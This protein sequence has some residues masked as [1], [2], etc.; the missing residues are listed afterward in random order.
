MKVAVI[1]ARGGSKRILGKNIKHFCGQPIISWSI[2]NAQKSSLFD[3]IIVST[4]SSEI[5]DVAMKYNAEVPFIRPANLADDYASTLA[6]MQHAAETLIGSGAAISH[7]CCIYATAPLLSIEALAEGMKRL[8]DEGVKF[9]FSAGRYNYPVQRAF[10][11][12]E[13]VGINFLFPENTEVRSQDL[14]EVYHDAGQFYWGKTNSWLTADQLLCKRALPIVIPT[15]RVQD[16][17]DMEDWVHAENL[18]KILRTRK[19]NNDI[20]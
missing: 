20:L 12:N 17:D 4:D 18:F 5:A 8:Q 14:S 6:V 10:S 19:K 15:S 13:K 11:Y 7:L 1:P 9:T 2:I 16:I 3:R